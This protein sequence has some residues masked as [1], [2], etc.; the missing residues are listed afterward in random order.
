[1]TSENNFVEFVYFRH[2]STKSRFVR[3]RVRFSVEH[4]LT[5]YSRVF[6]RHVEFDENKLNQYDKARFR[7]RL[8]AALN[9]SKKPET[10]HLIMSIA[11]GRSKL[12]LTNRLKLYAFIQNAIEQGRKWPTWLAMER[13]VGSTLGFVVTRNN[14]RSVC[15][16]AGVDWDVLLSVHRKAIIAKNIVPRKKYEAVVAELE[17][18]KLSM[19]TEAPELWE[20]IEAKLK[21]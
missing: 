13:D 11:K 3:H 2:G 5:Q 9:D 14:I 21:S 10:R 4:G 15:T 19:K 8:Y 6:R 7:L 17:A 1:M 20:R 12:N 16:S 18:L